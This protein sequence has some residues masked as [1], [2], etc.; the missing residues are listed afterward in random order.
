[1]VDCMTLI[2]HEFDKLCIVFFCYYHSS[3][4]NFLLNISH[5]LFTT[6]KIIFD[7]KEGISKVTRALYVGKGCD[8]VFSR[9]V[10]FLSRVQSQT[11]TRNWI[12]DPDCW[13]AYAVHL[14][15]RLNLVRAFCGCRV[16]SG[17]TTLWCQKWGKCRTLNL[18]ISMRSNHGSHLN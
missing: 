5:K 7:A 1:M 8:P 4:S 10:P 17:Y 16:F 15:Q 14:G 12:G 18:V 13:F 9:P 11:T 3:A 6:S 2:K